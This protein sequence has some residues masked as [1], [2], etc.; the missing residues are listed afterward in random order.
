MHDRRP[1]RALSTLL[2]CSVLLF[3]VV[4]PTQ[5]AAD[6][7][8]DTV[9]TLQ[10]VIDELR[11]QLALPVEVTASVVPS[12]TLLVSVQPVSGRTSFEMSF[13]QSFLDG[14]D[15]DEIRTIVA[16][17]LGHVWIFTHHPYLQTEVGANDIAL[18][19]VTR[20]SLERVYGKVWAHQGVKGSLT[21]FV[22][23]PQ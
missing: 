4:F 8:R 2:G 21:R 22:R 7:R 18:R 20:D 17:E 11:A 3:M 5:S 23:N 19:L 15:A 13:Q 1:R 16:H 14:L 9:R 10:S 6:E 12:N